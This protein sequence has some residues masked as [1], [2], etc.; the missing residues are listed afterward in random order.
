M[1]LYKDLTHDSRVLREAQVAGRGGAHRD[2]LLPGRRTAYRCTVPR[3][4]GPGSAIGRHSRLWQP[5]L[6]DRVGRAHPPRREAGL[7]VAG[8]RPRG[9][10][11]GSPD[12]R[13]SRSCRRLARARPQRPGCR[14]PVFD[15]G[16]ALI[17][18]SHEEFLETG[19][20][21]RLPRLA[22]SALVGL[23]RWLIGRSFGVITVNAGIA[24]DLR[25]AYSPKRLVIVR[26][27]PP[28]WS[29]PDRRPDRICRRSRLRRR[30][31]SPCSMEAS[32]ATEGSRR[33]LPRS[34][35]PSFG[36]STLFCL[37]MVSSPTGCGY[38]RKR[39]RCPDECMSIPRSRLRSS[40]IGWHPQTL[41]S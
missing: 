8:L 7:V 2:D 34:G 28:R 13:R 6:A 33:S 36:G 32:S 27:C 4:R 19:S 25:R 10:S 15:D 16:A 26:N 24:D 22:R 38:S 40:R 29:P 21:L 37:A 41:A 14:G 3:H 9:T 35:V 30:R 39:R 11:M 18:D 1:A 20:A 17:Y 5:L 12:R 31:R 23:E